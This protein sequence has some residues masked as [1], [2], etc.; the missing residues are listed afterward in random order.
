MSA[1]SKYFV[2]NIKYLYQSVTHSTFIIFS[3]LIFIVGAFIFI[4]RIV[5]ISNL[6]TVILQRTAIRPTHCIVYTSDL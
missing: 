2:I 5:T 3:V 6:F 1:P 4:T